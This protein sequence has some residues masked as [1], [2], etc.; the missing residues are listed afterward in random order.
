MAWKEKKQDQSKTQ[1]FNYQNNA[2]EYFQQLTRE[3]MMASSDK[4]GLLSIRT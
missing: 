1:A 4:D 3:K 2:R